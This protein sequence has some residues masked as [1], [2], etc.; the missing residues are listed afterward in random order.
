MVVV[1]REL[2]MLVERKMPAP[3]EGEA[4]QAQQ[5]VRLAGTEERG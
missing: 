2:F 5:Q 3:P 1:A 4:Q